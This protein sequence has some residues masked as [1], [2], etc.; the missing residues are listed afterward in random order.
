MSGTIIYRYNN[1]KLQFLKDLITS[2]RLQYA[3]FINRQ[4][5][6]R[7][8]C[9]YGDSIYIEF[10]DVPLEVYV[11]EE[12]IKD[13]VPHIGTITYRGI[14]LTVVE[15]DHNL[16]LLPIIYTTQFY[17]YLYSIWDSPYM[18]I[19]KSLPFSLGETLYLYKIKNYTIS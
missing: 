4:P 17:T 13:L 12:K 11:S 1:R 5:R 8:V 16:E 10:E 7:C 9:E 18:N 3:L 14:E 15:K 6:L 2:T 19:Y